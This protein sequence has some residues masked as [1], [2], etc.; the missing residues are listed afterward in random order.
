MTHF[1]TKDLT[2][3]GRSLT[4]EKTPLRRKTNANWVVGLGADVE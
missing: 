1:E 2:P 3:N 4:T